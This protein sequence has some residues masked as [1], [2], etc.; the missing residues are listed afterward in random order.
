MTRITR[1]GK[2]AWDLSPKIRDI[3][4]IR[5]EKEVKRSCADPLRVESV[6]SPEEPEEEPTRVV[7]VVPSP[8]SP[9]HVNEPPSS[10]E[11]NRIGFFMQSRR[12]SRPSRRG[13]PVLARDRGDTFRGSRTS[14]PRRLVEGKKKRKK[15]LSPHSASTL[16]TT[17]PLPKKSPH[18]K[19]YT[20]RCILI[21]PVPYIFFFAIFTIF[22]C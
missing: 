22:V 19:L 12:P 10:G 21:F 14:A 13:A 20:H 7:V 11:T 8:L 15:E 6:R 17:S 3:G 5:G 1:F 4:A 2:I 9:S 18:T 16:A